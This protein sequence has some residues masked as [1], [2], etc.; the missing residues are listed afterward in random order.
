MSIF[1][2]VKGLTRR[3]S[4]RTNE[5]C[6]VARNVISKAKA[7]GTDLVILDVHGASCSECA[8]Y[9]GRVYSISGSSKLFPKVPDF[10]FKYGCIHE[11]CSHEFWPYVHGVNDPDL[12]YTLS[13][14]KLQNKQY[15]KNIVAF[16]NRPFIDDRTDQCKK[17]DETARQQLLAEIAQQRYW[18][19]HRAEFEAK[20]AKEEQDYSWI[21]ANIPEKCPKS[22]SGFRRMK[23]QNTKNYQDLKQLA[24]EEGR[25]I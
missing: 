24:A 7:I 4:S 22:L 2:F 11:G 3:N 18:E 20:L 12:K 1:G 16:S 5:V 23:T 10:F 9:Q 13:I 14:H 21:Q 6:T 8:K 25:D 15:G 17:A 19:D